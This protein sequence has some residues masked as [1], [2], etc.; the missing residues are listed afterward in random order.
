MFARLFRSLTR[1]CIAPLCVACASVLGVDFAQPDSVAPDAGACHTDCAASLALDSEPFPQLAIGVGY[2]CAVTQAGGV[3]CWGNG[4]FGATGLGTQSQQTTPKQVALVGRARKVA[5]GA[6]HACALMED[7]QLYC[8]GANESGQ[9]G[10]G[11]RSD[12]STIP[13]RA[14]LFDPARDVVAGTQFTCIVSASTNAVQCVGLNDE[15]QLGRGTASSFEL[16]PVANAELAGVGPIAARAANVCAVGQDARAHCWGRNKG[17]ELGQST[18][19]FPF[20]A[21]PVGVVT[22]EDSATTVTALAVGEQSTCILHSNGH[23]WCWGASTRGQTGQAN[24]AGSTAPTWIPSLSATGIAAADTAFCAH[25][26]D[27][28]VR[29]WGGNTRNWLSLSPASDPQFEPRAVAGLPALVH[30]TMGDEEVCANATTG[31]LVCWGRND[32]GQIGNGTSGLRM[33]VGPTQ[34]ADF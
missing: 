11:Q 34:L 13:L 33:V 27:G 15:G 26:T 17:G 28:E 4:T 8:W 7:G 31:G 24:G 23:V 30:L 5:A 21:S 29:C 12:I 19:S 20:A 16:R 22:E 32:S 14:A 25:T 9:L 10:V 1:V 18:T 2:V 3:Y 6:S